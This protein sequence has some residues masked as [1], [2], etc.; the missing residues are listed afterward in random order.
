[1]N[2]RIA[3]FKNSPRYMQVLIMKVYFHYSQS[4]SE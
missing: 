4:S 3:Q 1:M 2:N